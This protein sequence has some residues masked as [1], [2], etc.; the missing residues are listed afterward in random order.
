M[1]SNLSPV[2][3]TLHSI[4]TRLKLHD[5]TFQVYESASERE[6]SEF[7]TCLIALDSTIEDGSIF[8]KETINQHPSICDFLKHCCQSSHYTFDI[9]KC[10]NLECT[11]C[12][13]PRLPL[14]TFNKF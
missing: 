6:I 12:K 7:W 3:S 5:K 4:F 2:K 13:P 10:G 1:S 9:L 8:W 11:I 14:A